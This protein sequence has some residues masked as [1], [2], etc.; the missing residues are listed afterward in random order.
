MTS[1]VRMTLT[2]GQLASYVTRQVNRLFD[3]GQ[4]VIEDDVLALLPQALGRLEHCFAHINNK[5]FFDGSSAVFNHLHGDQYAMFLYLLCNSAYKSGAS[6]GLPAKLFLLNKTLHGIDAF[7]E[8][9]LPSIFL[10][11]HPLGTV[12]GRARYA[13]YFLTYQRCGVGSNNDVYPKLGPYTTLR[14]GASVLGSCSL[15]QN[16]TIAADSLLLDRNLQDSN[17]YIGNPRD[18]IVRPN[19]KPPPVWRKFNQPKELPK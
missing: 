4:P 19:T 14:P 7:Y 16:N 6:N 2:H 18:F 17:V 9:E 5:Y 10:F 13:D 8:V 12:L 1:V 11:V 15:G 3:D